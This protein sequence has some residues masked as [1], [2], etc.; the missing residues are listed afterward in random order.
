MG[1]TDD[2]VARSDELVAQLR[3]VCASRMGAAGYGGA[4]LIDLFNRQEMLSQ[5]LA[6]GVCFAARGFHAEETLADLAETIEFFD[7]SLNAF[8][9]GLGMA[10]IPPAPTPEIEARL[11]A[12]RDIWTPV[13]P[14]AV[15]VTDGH[16]VS[17]SELESVNEGMSAFLVEMTE[18]VHLLMEYEAGLKHE[19]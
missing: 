17:T 3:Q 7:A 4:I 1:T 6:K 14:V 19:S 18:A 10:G 12:A 5:R 2:L 11:I 13:R 15:S 9:E 16:E 8:I